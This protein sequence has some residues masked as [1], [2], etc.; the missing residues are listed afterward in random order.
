MELSCLIELEK[1]SSVKKH[2]ALPVFALVF[3]L[4]VQRI[5]SLVSS[6]KFF[7][8]RCC[9]FIRI[10]YNSAVSEEKYLDFEVCNQQ[11]C[12]DKKQDDE[13]ISREE[14]EMVMGDLSLFCSTESEELPQR[15]CFNELSQ[16]FDEEPSLEEVKNA[17]DV[18]DVNRDGFIDAKELQRVLQILGFK[19]GSELGN[20]T[21]MIRAFDQNKDGKIDFQEFLK[22]M[23]NTC[24]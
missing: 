10:L 8:S 21:K 4:L 20:C 12:V 16:L 24:F 1:S 2:Q 14:V 17:F 19:E 7:F 13:S 22:F 15:F 11:A 9:S 5:L 18:F 6:V 3:L 23:E